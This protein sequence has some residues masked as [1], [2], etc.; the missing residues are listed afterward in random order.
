MTIRVLVADD[1]ALVRAGFVALLDAQDGIEVIAEAETGSAA[2]VAARELRPDVV[3]MDIRMPRMDGVEATR[4]LAGPQVRSPLR[5]LVLTTFDLDEYVYGAL[6]AGASGFLLKDAPP[7]ELIR[8]IHV[9][10]RGEALLAPSVTRRLITEFAARPAGPAALPALND[11]TERE[12]EVLMLVA[13]GH[14]NREIGQRLAVAETT[15]KTHVSRVLLKLDCRD[16]VQAVV[17]AYEQ[18]LVRP[19]E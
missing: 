9:I 8:A 15:V 4:R 6:R 19:G 11:L 5:V 17:L 7:E 10:A 18:G 12:R 2:L 16:R 1:P 14:S 13:K 3:L